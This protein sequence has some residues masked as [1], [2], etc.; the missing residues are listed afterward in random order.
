VF[1]C[2]NLNGGPSKKATVLSSLAAARRNGR[3][4]LKSIPFMAFDTPIISPTEVPVSA[5]KTWPNLK[6]ENKLLCAIQNNPLTFKL[7]K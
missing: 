5:L 4:G 2:L 3:L 1:D 7:E 6:I